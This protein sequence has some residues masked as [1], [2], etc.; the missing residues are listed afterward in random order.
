MVSCFGCRMDGGCGD[1]PAGR[2]AEVP[3]VQLCCLS[4]TSSCPD[5]VK[6]LLSCVGTA[7]WGA[8]R[9]GQTSSP[10]P[11]SFTNEAFRQPCS[12]HGQWWERSTGGGWA[13]PCLLGCCHWRGGMRGCSWP[14]PPP[15]SPLAAGE[16]CGELFVYFP[17]GILCWAV[18]ETQ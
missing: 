17:L 1:H 8:A 11:A 14:C 10:L 6:Q 15:P 16:C 4:R 7:W 9:R 13:I 5:F 12:S 3:V 2:A 18:L